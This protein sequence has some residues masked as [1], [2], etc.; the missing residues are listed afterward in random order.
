MT[1]HSY[2]VEMLNISKRFGGVQ[3]LDGVKLQIKPGE[4]HAL[5]GE[6]GAGKST[7]MKVLTGVYRKDEGEIF[8]DGEQVNIMNPQH[9]L[10]LGITAIY[11]ELA[12][13]NHLSVAENIFINKLAGDKKFIDW[14]LLRKKT[15][16]LLDQLGFTGISETAILSDISIACQQV[17]EIAKALTKKARVLILDEPTSLLASN[18]V[19]QLF[20]LLKKLKEEEN[21]AIIYIS[22]RLEEIFEICDRVTVL[23]DGKYVDTL[24]ICDV[25]ARQLATLMIGRDLKDYFPRRNATIGEK[26][27]E[28]KNIN[29]G[30]MVKNISFY[31]REGEVLGIGGLVGAGRTETA[32]AIIG[33][34]KRESGKIILR[35]K[36]IKTFSPRESFRNGIG[37]LPED[38]KG[39]GVLLELPIR[40]NTTLSSL[41]KYTRMFGRI[42]IKKEVK[43]VRNL[44][45]KLN[46]KATSIED[47][48]KSLSGGNQQKVAFSKLLAS[49]CRVFIFDEPTR[50]VDIGAKREIYALINALAEQGNAIIMIS[51]EMVE[52]IGMCDRV[53]IMSNGQVA[54][55]LEKNELNEENFISLSMGVKINDN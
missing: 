48:V 22:H 36:E 11:Q 33:A 21:V 5:V 16:K 34:D 53:M 46:I 27:F 54:G 7:L 45:K 47:L 15:R 6:N 23:K 26:V 1:N 25:D 35:G 44:A 20:S 40:Y 52:I 38:R 32:R 50:G 14:K 24:N 49:D 4:I 12:L 51:S 8:I 19:G 29:L 10:E 55:F 9:G 41:Y 2:R 39:Q 43:D 3:A 31:V 17:V 42:D 37:F 30:R 18:E 13:C 28:V